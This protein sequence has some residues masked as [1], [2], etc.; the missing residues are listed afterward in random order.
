MSERVAAA[1]AS[2]APTAIP[3]SAAAR[4]AKSLI[5][6][7]QYMQVFPKPCRE[8]AGLLLMLSETCMA[9]VSHIALAMPR[10]ARVAELLMPFPQI[11]SKTLQGLVSAPSNPMQ[12]VP[13][14]SNSKNGQ[15][16]H[17]L[18]YD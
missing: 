13:H 1:E 8:L 3:T 15:R 2:E 4:A 9:C 10:P 6:S 5:P 12:H 14:F 17:K 11:E 7:P 18:L 16:L